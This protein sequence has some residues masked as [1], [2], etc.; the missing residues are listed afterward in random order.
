MTTHALWWFTLD[1]GTGV[2]TVSPRLA[3]CG[4]SHVAADPRVG[5]SRERLF[6]RTLRPTRGSAATVHGHRR[7]LPRAARTAVVQQN[8]HAAISEVLHELP[9]NVHSPASYGVA[10]EH[11]PRR[12]PWDRI[13]RRSAQ[14]QR[15][16]R[17]RPAF[18]LA[19]LGL[20]GSHTSVPHGLRR[21]LC[22]DAPT[23]AST[24]P[25]EPSQSGHTQ[26]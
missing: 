12:E 21:G 17:C 25:E 6:S 1:R 26:L 10:I 13:G 9:G 24:L 20:A 5:R 14:P 7:V 23:G 11:S 16:V 19:P 4:K 8:A 2:S 22:F 3:A 15:G 18:S